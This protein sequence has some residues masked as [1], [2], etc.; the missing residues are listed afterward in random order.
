MKAREARFLF[1]SDH[2]ISTNTNY[3]DFQYLLEVYREQMA[4]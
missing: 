2:S 3:E 1:G 4:Y